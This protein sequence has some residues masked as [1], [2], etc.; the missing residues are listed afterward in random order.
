MKKRN[1]SNNISSF[2]THSVSRAEPDEAPVVVKVKGLNDVA[3]HS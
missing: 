2:K 1:M 3:V